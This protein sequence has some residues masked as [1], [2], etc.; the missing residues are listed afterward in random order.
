MGG[1]VVIHG[2]LPYVA[3]ARWLDDHQYFG[4]ARAKAIRLLKA[5]D[6]EYRRHMNAG[7]PEDDDA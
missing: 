5:L 2:A 6:G 4:E 1:G 3:I 7:K